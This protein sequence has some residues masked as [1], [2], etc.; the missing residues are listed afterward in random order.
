MVNLLRIGECRQCGK[1]CDPL[2]IP[3]RVEVYKRHK[4]MFSLWEPCRHFEYRNGKGLCKIYDS[5]PERCRAFPILPADIEALP[6]CG[7][8][9]IYVF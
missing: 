4:I 9:F 8:R 7:Y 6:E 5:R 2:T 3:A 1:C